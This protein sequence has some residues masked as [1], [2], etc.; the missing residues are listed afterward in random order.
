MQFPDDALGLVRHP[1]QLYEAFL[2]GIVMFVILFWFSTK[3]RPRG[4]L[5]GMFLCLYATFRFIVEF[6]REPDAHITEQLLGW[7]TRGQ[8]LCIPM[9]LVG[10]AFI[11]YALKYGERYKM[12][13]SS[14]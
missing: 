11:L 12:T 7:M 6:A 1:S 10:F 5:S 2:E 9:F 13:A 14:Q 8:L 4:L 3:P